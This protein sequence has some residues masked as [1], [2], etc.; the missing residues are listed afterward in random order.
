MNFYERLIAIFI[1]SIIGKTI[2]QSL[3]WYASLL[4]TFSG[5]LDIEQQTLYNENTNEIVSN[6]FTL[7]RLKENNY[8]YN[9][10]LKGS[11]AED[12]PQVKQYT[13]IAEN[14]D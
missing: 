10:K 9:Y 6:T 7:N 5:I 12:S 2:N 11:F 14:I 3:K 13:K 1:I 4:E 8:P